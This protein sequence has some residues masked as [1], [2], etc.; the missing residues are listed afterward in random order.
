MK[1][2]VLQKDLHCPLL[3]KTGCQCTHRALVHTHAS[4]YPS[5]LTQHDVEN[6]QPS[7]AGGLKKKKHENMMSLLVPL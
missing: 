3:Q 4:L 6:I 1:L 7:S 5:F 2:H